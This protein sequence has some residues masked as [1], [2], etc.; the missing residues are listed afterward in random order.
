MF[1]LIALHI[2]YADSMTRCPSGLNRFRN[3]AVFVP[4][5]INPGG[6]AA[7]AIAQPNSDC[8]A[9]APLNAREDRS[10]MAPILERTGVHAPGQ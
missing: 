2:H 6:V 4:D 8:R 9:A 1:S 5:T 3:V 10:D 7:L